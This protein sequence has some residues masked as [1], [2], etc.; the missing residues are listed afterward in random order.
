MRQLFT[1]HQIQPEIKTT[2]QHVFDL[3][4]K[5]QETCELVRK[6]LANSQQRNKIRFEKKSKHGTLTVGSSV[7][8]MHPTMQNALKYK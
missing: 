1:N 8:L 5:I 7:L 3:R 6:E 4:F 2:Y